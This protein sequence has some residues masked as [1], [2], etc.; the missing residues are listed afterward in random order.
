VLELLREKQ[1]AAYQAV[2]LRREQRLLDEQAI[3]GF[4]RREVAS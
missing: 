4:S 3:I 2:E 1:Q